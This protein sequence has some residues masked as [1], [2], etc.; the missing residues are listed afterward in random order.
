MFKFLKINYTLL[1]IPFIFLVG[2]IP[3]LWFK[4][5]YLAAGHDMSYPLAP[6]DFWLDRLYVWTDRIGSFG[7]NQTDAIAGIFIHGLQAL[8]YVLTGSLQL[9]QKLDF[10]FWFTLP[11]I[12]M[13]ILLR[14]LHPNKEDFVIRISGS[15]FYMLNHY[16]L[17]AW[18][19]AEMSKF[20]IVSALPLVVL[21][22]INVNLRS[23][24][25]FKNSILVG[26]VLFFLNGGAGIPLW[27]G[28]AITV[29]TTMVVTLLISSRPVFLKIRRALCFS[30]L[31]LFFVFLLNLY[32]IYPYVASYRYNYI[33]RLGAAG[34]SEGAIVWSKEISRNANFTNIIKLQGIP[35]W[36]DNPEHPYSN[37]ILKN[38]FFLLLAILFPGI[39]FVNIYTKRGES[40]N[41]VNYKLI[42]FGIL[43]VAIPFT[44][45]SHPP[46][47][48]FYDLALKYIPGFAIF[49]TPFYK[50]GMALWFAYSYLIALGLKQ[51]IDFARESNL[52]KLHTRAA[53]LFALTLFIIWVGAYNYPAFTGVFFNWSHKYSTRVKVPDYILEVKKELDSNNFSTRIL[54]LPQL[55]DGNKYISY[56]WKY[57]SLSSVPS[58]LSRK[59][60]LLN[61]AVLVD[62]ETGLVNAIYEQLEDS[63]QSSL[64]KY[65]GAEKAIVQ[66]D[67]KVDEGMEYS[68][69]ST[70]NSIN[71]NPKF[72]FDKQIGNWKFFNIN[73]EETKPLIY[74]PQNFFYIIAETSHLAKVTQIPG[75]G[76]LSDALA[77]DHISITSQLNPL[78]EYKKI[79]NLVIQAQ[80]LN[81]DEKKEVGLIGSNRP[82]ILPSNPFYFI[83]EFID[84]WSMGKYTQPTEKIDYLLGTMSKEAAAMDV[85]IPNPK[86]SSAVYY[87]LSK[88]SQNFELI[89]RH[90][91]EIT[92]EERRQEY[93]SRILV[94]YWHL[95]VSSQKWRKLDLVE[96][97]HRELDRLEDLL[98]TNVQDL[99]LVQEVPSAGYE[100]GTKYYKIDVPQE[101]NYKLAVYNYKVKDSEALAIFVNEDP[102]NLKRAKADSKWYFSETVDLNGGEQIV[103]MPE[104]TRTQTAYEGFE[105]KEAPGTSECRETDFGKIDPKIEYEMS[106]EYLTLAD[107]LIEIKLFE[108]NSQFPDGKEKST[109]SGVRDELTPFLYKVKVKYIP[110]RLAESAFLRFCIDGD[111]DLPTTFN[112]QNLKIVE[113]YPDYLVFLTQ[114]KPA[115]TTNDYKL[116][117]VALNQTAYLVRVFGINDKFI[118]NFNSRFDQQWGLRRIDPD[119]ADKYFTGQKK[120]Y[121]GGRVVEYE[122]K[123]RHILSEYVFPREKPTEPPDIR[124]NTFSNGWLI[125]PA[126]NSEM[127]FLIEYTP[128]STA[129]KVVV[130]SITSLV[131][132]CLLY[133][134]FFL[135][136]R[137]QND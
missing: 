92:T 91:K 127:A 31:S 96:S 8:L 63:S 16:L 78:V 104:L 106:F 70:K 119:Q 41:N 109:L 110:G 28:L 27:G 86:N 132:I 121:L 6:I 67:F 33:H 23:G 7:S 44:A 101:G 14:S 134:V 17:Q 51:L 84:R 50:F 93:S 81:C 125:D 124:L 26:V 100:I 18:I 79:Q 3:L 89:K 72:S 102:Y 20:S 75:F 105:I 42:F 4:E 22:V 21:A 39:A 85:I 83:I 12:T 74:I 61:D 65:T 113:K 35:D 58:M 87:V 49:R 60:V 59:S 54:M 128:Q 115:V 56:D 95:L 111:L 122:R 120:Q 24:S 1:E 71:Y 11:G 135:F 45:G 2:L 116:Q 66:D 40:R 36:Y 133:L 99:D 80:C 108:K 114:E 123:D 10:I 15:L 53:S 5:G 130:V 136:T 13:Y 103:I 25:I 38:Y 94:Y 19:I 9:A 64:L 34:G 90:Y 30:M 118:L 69:S 68:M 73:D 32:W 55:H 82:P 117:F 57:F 126:D 107:R 48:F 37:V 112:L 129:Y 77:F 46:T 62:N 98:T 29:L 137:G 52:P 88:W 131:G 43:L 47:G 97:T 76:T